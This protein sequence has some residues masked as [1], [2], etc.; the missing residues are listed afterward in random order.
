MRRF[1]IPGIIYDQ[2]QTALSDQPFHRLVSGFYLVQ[3]GNILTQSRRPTCQG[4]HH[5]RLLA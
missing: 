1:N 3:T 2:E 4:Q 5:V